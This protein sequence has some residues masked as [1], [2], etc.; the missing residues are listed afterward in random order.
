MTFDVADARHRHRV[1]RRDRHDRAGGRRVVRLS[2]ATAGA[3]A[4]SRVRH[5]R[6]RPGGRRAHTVDGATETYERIPATLT[7]AGASAFSG[8]YAAGDEFGTV[9]VTYTKAP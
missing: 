8:Y 1:L 4:G 6:P 3:R 7:A 5:A 2:G 9:S